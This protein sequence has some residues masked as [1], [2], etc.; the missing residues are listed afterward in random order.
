MGLGGRLSYMWGL[1]I[2]LGTLS[3]AAGGL[4]LNIFGVGDPNRWQI[5]SVAIAIILIGTSSTWWAGR[6]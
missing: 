2:A 6:C 4:L 3:Y 5:A 1:T